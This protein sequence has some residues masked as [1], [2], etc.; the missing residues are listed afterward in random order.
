M[1]DLSLTFGGASTE[2]V[3]VVLYGDGTVHVVSMLC[4]KALYSWVCGNRACSAMAVAGNAVCVAKSGTRTLALYTSEKGRVTHC[5]SSPVD[6]AHPVAVTALVVT[7]ERV[8]T[9]AG[10]QVRC[11]Q[12][13]D[14]DGGSDGG[15][16]GAV[17]TVGTSAT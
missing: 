9:S 8:F 15:S 16:D 14:S 6:T 3:A 7:R 17:G 13:R 1:V 5:W 12:T 11:F 10:D 4:G 2:L